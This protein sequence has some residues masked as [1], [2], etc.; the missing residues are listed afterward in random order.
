[1]QPLLSICIPTY[2][3]ADY[4]AENITVLACQLG[5][6]KD[7]VEFVISDNGSKDRTKETILQLKSSYNLNLTYYFQENSLD[8]EDNFDFVVDKS[9]GT[10]VYLMGDD[11]IVSPDFINIIFRLIEKGYKVIHFNKLEGD[12]KCSNNKLFHCDFTELERKFTA[13][14]FIRTMLW[15]PNFMS[16]I[17]FSKKVWEEGFSDE[18]RTMYGY[19]FLGRIYNGA[20]KLNVICCYYYMPL[21]LMRNPQRA[22][23]INYPMYWFVG[24]S[25]IFK[26]LDN[27]LPGIYAQWSHYIHNEKQYHFVQNLSAVHLSKTQYK[28]KRDEFMVHLNKLQ[29]FT[30]D[31]HLSPFSCKLTRGLFYLILKLIYRD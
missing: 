13:S 29:R 26:L 18:L 15:R 7:N 6:Y 14:E 17:I 19:R 10:Y 21:L 4:L 20:I 23:S 22:W 25:N 11:D 30:Y 12:A 2:N 8:F 9:H 24:M 27:Q 1:M 28:L 3:R 31:F 5:G 16:S